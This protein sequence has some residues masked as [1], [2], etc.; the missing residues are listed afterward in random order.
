MPVSQ[1][2]LMIPS[3]QILGRREEHDLLDDDFMDFNP[4]LEQLGEDYDEH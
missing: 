4:N 2:G 3:G 1:G